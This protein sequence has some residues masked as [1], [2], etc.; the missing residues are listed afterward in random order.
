MKTR[1]NDTPRFGRVFM[2]GGILGASLYLTGCPWGGSGGNLQPADWSV[3]TVTIN[4]PTSIEANGAA[5]FRVDVSISRQDSP[6]RELQG[7]IRVFDDD[8]DVPAFRRIVDRE[9]LARVL[10]KFPPGVTTASATV[11]LACVAPL[12]GELPF[13]VKGGY[14]YGWEGS[15]GD[16][17]EVHAFFISKNSDT[18]LNVSC[19]GVAGS[20][21]LGGACTGNSECSSGLVCNPSADR[22]EEPCPPPPCFVDA[23][24]R[25]KVDTFDFESRSTVRKACSL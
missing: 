3:N 23:E 6:A 16:P 22:C 20:V 24:G 13:S 5:E 25:C 1:R 7:N 17:A 4:G 8:M 12:N 9:E 18:T 11:T 21:G 10:V 19:T 2:I 15:N 14:G